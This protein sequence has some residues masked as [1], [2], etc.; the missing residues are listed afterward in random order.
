[1]MLHTMPVTELATNCYIISCDGKTALIIDPGGEG[2]RI[3]AWLREN[4][5]R[6]EWIVC[7]HGHG[8]HIGA[9]TFLKETFIDLRIAIGADDVEYLTSPMKNMSLLMARRIKSPPADRLLSNG[10]RFEFQD[11]SFDVI[12]VPGHTPGG[13]CLYTRLPGGNDGSILFSGDSLFAGSI[14]RSDIPGGDG[15]LLVRTIREK[16]LVLPPETVVYPGHGPQTT[17]AQEKKS[18]PWL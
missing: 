16:L 6:P 12:A 2:E 18:N 4:N 8:D 5:L 11:L 1:M 14:G 7:T 17:I 13:L 9:N 3:A 15:E 10:D